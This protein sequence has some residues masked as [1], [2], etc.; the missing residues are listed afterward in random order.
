MLE[1]LTIFTASV[2]N[3]EQKESVEKSILWR[4]SEVVFHTRGGMMV[5]HKY[6]Q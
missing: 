6:L 5:I 1:L 4:L 2:C 3:I